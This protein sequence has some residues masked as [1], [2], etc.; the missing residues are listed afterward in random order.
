FRSIVIEDASADVVM[1]RHS[2]TGARPYNVSAK[3]KSIVVNLNSHSGIDCNVIIKI[4]FS[5]CV[6]IDE[7]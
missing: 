4:E 1:V 5:A 7:L 6:L 2:T 3:D